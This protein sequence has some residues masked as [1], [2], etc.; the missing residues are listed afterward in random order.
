MLVHKASTRWQG[1]G[2]T[3]CALQ[4]QLWHKPF[5]RLLWPTAYHVVRAPPGQ[6]LLRVANSCRLVCGTQPHS[7]HAHGRREIVPAYYAGAPIGTKRG[8]PHPALRHHH[9]PCSSSRGLHI[10]IGPAGMSELCSIKLAPPKPAHTVHSHFSCAPHH[11]Q[12][13]ATAQSVQ[14]QSGRLPP[15]PSTMIISMACIATASAR[16]PHMQGTAPIH[17]TLSGDRTHDLWLIRP[18]L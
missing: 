3:A 11:H 15:T 13:V 18:S 5:P 1:T 12:N 6:T 8:M 7:G 4:T 16:V 9:G 2:V 17:V 10:T 14:Y